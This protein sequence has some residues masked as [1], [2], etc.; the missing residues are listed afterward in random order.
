MSRHELHRVSLRLPRLPRVQAFNRV[1][2][3]RHTFRLIARPY[4]LIPSTSTP[5]NAPAMTDAPFLFSRAN[6]TASLAA[7][8]HPSPNTRGTWDIVSTC[9][10]TL[11]ICVWKAVH[12]NVPLHR[13]LWNI[14][15]KLEWLVVGIIA[16]DVLLFT[17]C[18]QLQRAFRNRHFAR[19][20]LGC[21]PEPPVWP[22][23]LPRR[24]KCVCSRLK[25]CP[26][27]RHACS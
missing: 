1:A 21:P 5:S 11:L 22:S 25:V 24:L 6:S 27:G 9:L 3:R 12:I 18:C 17:A 10:A 23:Y 14:M 2:K 26:L 4:T 16:P 13:S 19:E 15:Y 8:W 7:S 20:H